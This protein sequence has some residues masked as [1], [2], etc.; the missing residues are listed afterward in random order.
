MNS[1]VTP[2]VVDVIVQRSLWG[3]GNNL[4]NDEGDQ[5][6]SSL[7]NPTSKLS[8][9]LGIALQS[10]G[11]PKKKMV[12]FLIPVELNASEI[13]KRLQKLVLK[14]FFEVIKTLVMI[15]DALVGNEVED[16]FADTDFILKDEAHR[17]R[18]LHKYGLLVGINFTFVD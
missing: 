7:Y 16:S 11:V 13:P 14:E 8:C 3:S 10:V 1:K 5:I 12:N 15:N 2:D 17:E 6:A 4:I 9:C 18:L